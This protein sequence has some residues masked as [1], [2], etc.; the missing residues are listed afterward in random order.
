LVIQ[1]QPFGETEMTVFDTDFLPAPEGPAP[2]APAEPPLPSWI[3]RAPAEETD[4]VLPPPIAEL[5]S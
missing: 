2:E 4:I 3:V 1:A 5:P